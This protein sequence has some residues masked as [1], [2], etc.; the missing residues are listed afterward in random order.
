MT[1]EFWRDVWSSEISPELIKV[2]RHGLFVLAELVEQ[3]WED[4]TRELAAEIRLQRQSFGLSPIDRRRLQWE[5]ERTTEAQEKRKTRAA[6]AETVKRKR[7]DPRKI[8]K[9][10]K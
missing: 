10:V 8:L 7:S 5:V 6:R 1:M 2:D 3:F 9:M 4:P